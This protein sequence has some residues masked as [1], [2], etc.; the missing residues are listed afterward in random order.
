MEQMWGLQDYS[1][2]SPTYSLDVVCRQPVNEDKAAGKIIHLGV[3][4]YFCSPQCMA[5]FEDSP[6]SYVGV[7]R[8]RGNGIALTG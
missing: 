1:D 4:Y 3:T 6:G 7:P 8:V 2:G 5:A